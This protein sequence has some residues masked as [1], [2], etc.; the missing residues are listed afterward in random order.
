[1]PRSTG[2]DSDVLRAHLASEGVACGASGSEADSASLALSVTPGTTGPL[3]VTEG[4]V[5]AQRRV[6]EFYYFVTREFL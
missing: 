2:H 6:L 3:Q 5:E 4:L 1:M